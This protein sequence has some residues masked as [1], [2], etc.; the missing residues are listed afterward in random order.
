[1]KR[2]ILVVEDEEKLRRVLELQLTSAGFEVD[3]ARTAEEALKLVDRADLVLTDLRLPQM[4]GLELLAAIRRQNSHTPV[5]VMTAFGTIETAVRGHESRRHR[6]PVEAVLA[7]SP[8]DGG[9]RRRSKCARCATRTCKLREELGRRY[10]F[11]NIVGRSARHAGNLCHHRARGAHARHGAAGGRKR[12]RQGPDRARHPFP[13]AAPRPAAGEDQ[14]HRAPRKPDG[15]R[16]VRLR[17]GRVHR[18]HTSKPGKFEQADTGTV[19]LDEIGDVPA[20][21]S[22]EAA[23]RPAGARVRAPGQ[24]RDAAHRR[25]R[26]RRHQSGSAR[27]AGAGHLS[28]GSLLPAERG[29]ASTFRRCANAR[30]TFRFWPSTSSHKLAPDT[31]SRVESITDA[32]MDK[33]MAYHWP[34]NVRELENVIERSLVM[35]TGTRAGRGGYQAG[36]RAARRA[37]QDRAHFPARR[38]DARSIRAGDH[39][40]GA[41]A[42]RRQQ[43]P[44]RAAAGADAQCAAVPAD[45]DGAGGL[46]SRVG[47]AYGCLVPT[48]DPVPQALKTTVDIGIHFEVRSFL[49]TPLILAPAL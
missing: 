46:R 33:L 7:R 28:R 15:E 12:R 9:R 24:Q 22:G 37:A 5:V 47:A 40:R 32:A 43:E 10:D 18:R 41:A 25:A 48:S 31:G 44:G 1:M 36:K 4:D 39:P 38:D 2:R 49:S 29:A 45:A 26:D 42:G 13:L 3:K 16:A 19:F 17:E 35:C 27:G 34:G 20:V 30:R 14:L 8:D 23:A 21:H 11:D 6:F